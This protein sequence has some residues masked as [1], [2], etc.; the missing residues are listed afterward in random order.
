MQSTQSISDLIVQRDPTSGE[1][2]DFYE[3]NY[4]LNKSLNLKF[5]LCSH[6]V[7]NSQNVFIKKMYSFIRE[8]LDPRVTP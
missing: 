8:I 5:V 4:T 7:M 6:I 3:V 1:I 2:L